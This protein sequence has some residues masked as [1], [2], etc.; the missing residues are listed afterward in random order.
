MTGI[1]LCSYGT[2][3]IGADMDVASTCCMGI[4]IL[5]V[6]VMGFVA[7]D[8][9]SAMGMTDEELRRFK[10]RRGQI[11]FIWPFVL[12]RRLLDDR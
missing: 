4:C 10:F 9:G 5:T 12:Y 8:L 1:R 7:F 2:R 3:C 6:A 11:I